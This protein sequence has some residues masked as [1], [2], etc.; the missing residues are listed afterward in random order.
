MTDPQQKRNKKFL[1]LKNHRKK[2]TNG[3][4]FEKR[5]KVYYSLITDECYVFCCVNS[6]ARKTSALAIPAIRSSCK[7]PK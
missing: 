2:R 7:D 6:D 4:V 5:Q 1:P 3:I